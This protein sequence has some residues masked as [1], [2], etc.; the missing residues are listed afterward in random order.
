MTFQRGSGIC[1]TVDAR[2]ALGLDTRVI[3]VPQPSLQVTPWFM[4]VA[5]TVTHAC[6]PVRVPLD[7][8]ANLSV[9][10]SVSSG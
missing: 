3:R 4:V 9:C 7:L 10:L 8:R 2:I 6:E 5:G 1:L